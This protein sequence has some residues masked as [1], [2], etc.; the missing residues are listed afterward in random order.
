M[1]EAAAEGLAANLRR[2]R[3]ARGMTQAELGELAGVSRNYIASLELGRIRTPGV[4]AC[5]RLA[6]ALGVTL[7]SLLG[8]PPLDTLPVRT[9][10]YTLSDA[11]RELEARLVLVGAEP[12][13]PMTS[14]QSAVYLPASIGVEELQA[15]ARIAVRNHLPVSR[16]VPDEWAA[17]GWYEAGA[18]AMAVRDENS[19]GN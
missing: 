1:E 3:D 10:L 17:Q 7:E 8:R 18:L 11:Q 15:A 4:F 9:R 19:N 2:V 5:Y 16:T 6:K 14:A 12:F 13:D